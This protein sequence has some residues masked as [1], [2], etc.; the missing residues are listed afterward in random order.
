M[1]V[2]R[3]RGGFAARARTAGCGLVSR[4]PDAAQRAALAAW[5][6]ADPG[7]IKARE[8]RVPALRSSAARCAA[9]GTRR[10]LPLHESP[11]G[12]ARQ[13]G[14]GPVVDVG[15]R[16][17]RGAVGERHVQHLAEIFGRLRKAGAAGLIHVEL[18]EQFVARAQAI[19]FAE[20]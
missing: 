11:R 16:L 6:A 20:H 12:D 8:V 15:P 13:A 18:A 19:E 3:A 7:P 4:A 5:C 17:A 10:N 1:D 2:C 14:D 9:S